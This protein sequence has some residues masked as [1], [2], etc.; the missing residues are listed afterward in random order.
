MG[1]ELTEYE[2]VARAIKSFA[3]HLI[4]GSTLST[5]G[6][7]RPLGNISIEIQLKLL[8]SW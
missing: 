8:A 6:L 5:V 7:I 4:K 3:S 1:K 2:F